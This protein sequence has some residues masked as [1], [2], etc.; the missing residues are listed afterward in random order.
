VQDVWL[1]NKVSIEQ[2]QPIAR[3][4]TEHTCNY[5]PAT[6]LYASMEEENDVLLLRRS[7]RF[8]SHR[9]MC[10]MMLPGKM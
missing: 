3:M 7:N 10:W 8:S 2:G 4:L 9:D 5:V 6:A 1:Q